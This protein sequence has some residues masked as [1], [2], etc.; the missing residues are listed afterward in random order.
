[1]TINNNDNSNII[2][3]T[4]DYN[5]IDNKNSSNIFNAYNYA[6]GAYDAS[7]NGFINDKT[8]I[9]IDSTTSLGTI[10]SSLKFGE[11]PVNKNTTNTQWIQ[12]PTFN[13]TSTYYTLSIV[14]K[15]VQSDNARYQSLFTFNTSAAGSAVNGYNGGLA[16]TQS[17]TT[18]SFQVYDSA[19]TIIT[20]PNL[21]D[22]NPH[23]LTYIF[24]PSSFYSQ[25]YIDGTL[26]GASTQGTRNTLTSNAFGF[27]YCNWS[28]T[29]YFNGWLGETRLYNYRMTE[30]Q[31]RYLY[32][33]MMGITQSNSPGLSYDD[34]KS[35]VDSQLNLNVSSNQLKSELD[36]LIKSN[37]IV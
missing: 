17:S 21:F 36:H 1:M 5:T 4:D 34:I 11:G 23:H 19:N 37:K 31:V 15:Y 35:F 22:G 25:L 10:N 14:F 2:A 30:T 9:Y 26:C 20:I 33:I 28:S 24:G 6:T 3:N 32:N 29:Q 16:L 8:G 12:Y 13:S 18:T 27:G 7:L